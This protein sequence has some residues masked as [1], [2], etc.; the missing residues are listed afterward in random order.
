LARAAATDANEGTLATAI[1]RSATPRRTSRDW[2]RPAEAGIRPRLTSPHALWAA[3]RERPHE[4][5][6]LT[7]GEP[8]DRGGLYR[9]SLHNL[10]KF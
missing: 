5:I 2:M 1:E 10:L 4:Q 9:S 6:G 8:Y 7:V 3:R